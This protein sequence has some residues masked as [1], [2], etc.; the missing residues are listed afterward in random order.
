MRSLAVGRGRTYVCTYMRSIDINKGRGSL[1]LAP[2]IACLVHWVGLHKLRKL[3]NAEVRIQ[4]NYCMH[5]SLGGHS[6][7][8]RVSSTGGGRGEASPPNSPA[9]PPRISCTT[10]SQHFSGLL[11]NT[12]AELL[13]ACTAVYL[14]L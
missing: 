13:S 11:H 14:K 8:A 9:S 2:I 3:A 7:V 1:T 4:C 12:I 5:G 10:N 6:L